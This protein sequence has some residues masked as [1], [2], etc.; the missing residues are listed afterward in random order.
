MKLPRCKNPDVDDFP[1]WLLGAV[2][3]ELR[4]RFEGVELDDARQVL[5]AIDEA[6]NRND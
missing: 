5:R 2:R 4:R 1:P 3:D 6:M